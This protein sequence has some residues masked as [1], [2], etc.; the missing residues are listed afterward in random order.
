MAKVTIQED[1]LW[2]KYSKNSITVFY[3]GYFYSH[4]IS[5][6]V[7]NIS[8]QLIEDFKKIIQNIDGHFALVIVKKNL[9]IVAVDKIRSTPLFFTKIEDTFS[10]T[11]VQ[12]TGNLQICRR[13]PSSF[14]R[15]PSNTDGSFKLQKGSFNYRGILLISKGILQTTRKQLFGRGQ[16]P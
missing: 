3:K 15:D 5:E 16:G 8:G 12:E 2:K 9:T 7:E 13:D 10:K 1:N 14:K 11:R 4:S 6:I